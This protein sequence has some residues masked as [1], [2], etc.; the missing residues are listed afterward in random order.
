VHLQGNRYCWQNIRNVKVSVVLCTYNGERY[1]Q[2]QLNSLREQTR[3]P[4]ELIVVDDQST[5]RTL[6]IVFNFVHTAIFPTTI[7]HNSENIGVTDN[8]ARGT[9]LAH[10]DIIFYCDQDD[11]WKR[12]K[13]ANFCKV[14]DDN[15]DEVLVFSNGECVDASLNP[16]GYTI[17]ESVGFDKTRRDMW[18]ND[19]K[20]DVLMKSNVV[21]GAAMAV[22]REFAMSVMP[23]SPV[24]IH[25]GWLAILAAANGHGHLISENTI[26]YR[27]H[28]TNQIGATKLSIAEKVINAKFKGKSGILLQIARYFDLL[29][30]LQDDE[31]DDE[32]LHLVIA[33]L[34]HLQKREDLQGNI[35]K[36]IMPICNELFNGNYHKYS[37]GLVSAIRDLVI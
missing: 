11:I 21:T 32:L 15:P 8:Y 22:K 23:F 16:L 5:D 34:M 19:K 2:E 1:L 13:I 26:L 6:S 17:W 35:F 18:R 7:Y 25:D 12:D 14:F 27:Q 10:G 20:F 37:N 9:A 31:A 4:D 36:R 29:Q 33:K 24:W 28:D 30:R 3:L